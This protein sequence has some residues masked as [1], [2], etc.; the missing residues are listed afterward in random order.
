MLFFDS[1]FISSK[2]H[3]ESKK[4]A[5]YSAGGINKSVNNGERSPFFENK[6]S[7]HDNTDES[8]N[9]IPAEFFFQIKDGKK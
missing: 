1:K 8:S 5:N 4:V 3:Y 9:V 6:E 7:G 2:L